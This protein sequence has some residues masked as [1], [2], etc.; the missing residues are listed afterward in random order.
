MIDIKSGIKSISGTEPT[1]ELIARVTS[2]AHHFDIPKNDAMFPILVMLD[3]YHG[4]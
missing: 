2:I 3:Q 4:V 1:P